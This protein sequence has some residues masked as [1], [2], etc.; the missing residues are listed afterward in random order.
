MVVLCDNMVPRTPRRSR[1]SSLLSRVVPD[2]STA[3]A[4]VPPVAAD[5][6]VFDVEDVSCATSPVTDVS[7]GRSTVQVHVVSD[8]CSSYCADDAAQHGTRHGVDTRHGVVVHGAGGGEGGAG[9]VA[10]L[11]S[12]LSRQLGAVHER[13]DDM[14]QRLDV[15]LRLLA[16]ASPQRRPNNLQVAQFR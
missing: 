8:S 1:W 10:E 4:A 5:N 15:I 2:T 16:N 3:S 6:E 12:E 11:R 7:V 9:E 14:S 13:I